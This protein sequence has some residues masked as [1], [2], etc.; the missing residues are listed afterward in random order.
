MH[1]SLTK[2][3]NNRNGVANFEKVDVG[4]HVDLTDKRRHSNYYYLVKLLGEKV[5]C[6]YARKS[7]FS[8]YKDA[9]TLS[10]TNIYTRYRPM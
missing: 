8:L 9:C 6:M 5:F 4:L 2:S 10:S 1:V 7:V 3:K